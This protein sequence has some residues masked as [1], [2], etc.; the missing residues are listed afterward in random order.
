MSEEVPVF[1]TPAQYLFYAV[2]TKRLSFINSII[3]Q[4]EV[5]L[6]SVDET[7]RTPLH[8]AAEL[9]SVDAVRALLRA[10]CPVD[11][12]CSIENRGNLTAYQL[13]AQNI[14]VRK[15]FETDMLQQIGTGHCARIS[16]L[17]Q[18][19]MDVN[20]ADQATGNTFLHWAAIFNQVEVIRLLLEHGAKVDIRN[21]A[22]K[23]AAECSTHPAVRE[24]F[25]AHEISKQTV[26]A[27]PNPVAAHSTPP[28]A[29]SN[30]TTN[31]SIASHQSVT[32]ESS[33]TDE[34]EHLRQQIK[35]LRTIAEERLHTMQTLRES[36]NLILEDRGVMKLVSKLQADKAMLD[37]QLAQ[38]NETIIIL[39]EKLQRYQVTP[40]P[41]PPA[42]ETQ[43]QTQP[44]TQTNSQSNST[45]ISASEV[46][47]NQHV[48][49][50]QAVTQHVSDDGRVLHFDTAREREL[51][52]QVQSLKSRVRALE[53]QIR[54]HRA[55]VV[56]IAPNPIEFT[57]DEMADQRG[58]FG[59]LISS[60]YRR[61]VGDSH[62]IE[63]LP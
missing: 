16:K 33:P 52:E 39:K 47:E 28:S 54:S 57:R 37:A 26:F 2:R 10:G 56:P 62:L 18:S 20:T 46:T 45:A 38:S 36:L 63:T 49:A 44:N 50:E 9:G 19:G 3:K 34:N 43:S 5:E 25:S 48:S 41:S 23:I 4:G 6:G 14:D 8:V 61:I 53:T 58:L 31:E 24:A 11:V 21:L 17:L 1:D 55:V 30:P 13:G 7:G 29:P 51:H 22:G 40:E 59:S 35:R 60:L 32:P 42:I 15:A 12:K 27:V